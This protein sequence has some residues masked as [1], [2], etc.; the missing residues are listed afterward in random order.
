MPLEVD[1]IM[2]LMEEKEMRLCV[3]MEEVKLLL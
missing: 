3:P 2:E 1:K